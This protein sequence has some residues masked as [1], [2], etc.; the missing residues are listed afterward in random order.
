MSLA[1]P[2]ARPI[3]RGKPRAQTEFGYKVFVAEDERG[4]IVSHRVHKGNPA[5]VG[6][7]VP[8][9]DEV[10]RLTGRVP[11]E[12]VGDRGF[13][14]AAVKRELW[15]RGVKRVG[16]PRTGRPGKARQAHQRTRPFRRMHRWRVGIEARISHL[17]RG[18]GLA[19]T[20]LRG[21]DGAT[22]WTGCGIFAYNLQRM[23]AFG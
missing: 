17:K 19:R 9:V 21:T 2:D 23:A 16:I 11:A 3:R 10:R 15:E 7:L 20:R 13:G 5:D 8:A 14:S 18:F 6:Q 12:V 4:F 22:T 1:D